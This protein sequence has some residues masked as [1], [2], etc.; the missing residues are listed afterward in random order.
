MALR[1]GAAR[2]TIT[3]PLGTDMAGYFNVRKATGVLDDLHGRAVV[4]EADGGKVAFVSADLCMLADAEVAQVRRL[5]SGW[6]AIPEG[7]IMVAAT[8]V[9]TG[10]VTMGLLS[11]K[12]DPDYMRM[13]IANLATAI[14]LANERLTDAELYVGSG[15][16]PSLVFNRRYV[17]KDGSV[18]TNP[19]VRNPD[20]IKPAGPTDPEVVVIHVK[21]RS[22]KSIAVL[23]NY[24]NHVDV[25]GGTKFSADFPGVMAGIIE[26]ALG[27]GVETL[28]LMGTSGNVN[29]VDVG[30]PGP[31]GVPGTSPVDP[32]AAIVRLK[33]Y[34]EAKR[35]GLVLA[36]RVLG[37]L[38]EARPVANPSLRVVRDFAEIPRRKPCEEDLRKARELLGIG[39]DVKGSDLVD[40]DFSGDPRLVEKVY[41]RE[42]LLLDEDEKKADTLEFWAVSLGDAGLVGIPSEAFVEIGIAIKQGSPFRHTAVVTLAN[43]SAGYIPM[44]WSFAQGG[45]EPRLARSSRL[46]PEAAGIVIDRCLRALVGAFAS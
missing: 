8:H 32:D 38:G 6:T 22:G 42:V 43:G 1:A 4:L 10:P 30:C 35:I 27:E 34:D 31:A 20:I 39:P 18:R 46:A 11:G 3:P 36:G 37:A 28:Y 40:V 41:A 16:A 12:V 13:L 29:H 5:A 24:A 14:A 2:V 19:G 23:V 26:D 33:G 7:N 17:M 44:P 9:H 25:V 15:W 45:Y 21:A